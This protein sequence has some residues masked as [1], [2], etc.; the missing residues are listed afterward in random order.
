LIPYPACTVFLDL[1]DALH[2][3]DGSGRRK[4]G[5][6]VVGLASGPMYG[7]GRD[8]DL[9]QVRLSPAVA[10]AALGPGSDIGKSVLTLEELWG[11]DAE[12]IQERLRATAAWEE[13]FAIVYRA[14]AQRSAASRT[15]DHEIAFAWSRLAATSG[16]VRIEQLAGELGWSRQ[17]LWSRFR[18]Q[19]GITPKYAARL[20]RFDHAA[21]RLAAGHSAAAV[22][23]DSGF[24]DQSHLHH[25]AMAFAGMTTSAVAQAQW[26]VVD[27][28]AWPVR[29]ARI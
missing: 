21:H 18:A 27:P 8:I 12:R 11:R 22:A 25:D 2:T 29:M 14:L 7:T 28:I 10:H 3:E 20:I 13:R 23:D 26:L 9:L 19:V 24:V 6:V 17:R 5:S 4:H 15:V 1:G 16:Q